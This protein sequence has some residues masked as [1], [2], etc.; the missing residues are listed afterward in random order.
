LS[1]ARSCAAI[2]ETHSTGWDHHAAIDQHCGTGDEGRGVTRQKGDRLRN[3]LRLPDPPH[4]VP[5]VPFNP[6]P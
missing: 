1:F 4:R 6:F 5:S 2:G 3:S